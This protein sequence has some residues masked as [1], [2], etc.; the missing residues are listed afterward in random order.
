MTVRSYR[1]LRV[2]QRSIDL[3]HA[4]YEIARALPSEE[5]S[6]LS[7]QIRRAAGSIHANIAEGHTR[8]HRKEFVQ[9]LVIAQASLAELESHLLVVERLGY[10]EP[11][12]LSAT[13][14]MC[15]EV[16]RML[17][18][19]RGHLQDSPARRPHQTPTARRP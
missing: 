9:F 10:A 17:R 7:D 6:A 2:W 14:R 15:D 3:V 8:A 19:M 1:D 12:A 13:L 11:R 18:V 16:G 4:V 5:R